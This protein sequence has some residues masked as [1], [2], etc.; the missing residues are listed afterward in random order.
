MIKRQK[1]YIVIIKNEKPYNASAIKQK[2]LIGLLVLGAI[3]AY[4]FHGDVE[5]KDIEK[6]IKNGKELT[7]IRNKILLQ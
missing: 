3:G 5:V 7:N 2:E 4:W 1:A 6:D